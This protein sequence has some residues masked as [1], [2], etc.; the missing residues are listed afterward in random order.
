LF[1]PQF[2]GYF[3]KA[4][5]MRF[6]YCPQIVYNTVK[7]AK[8]RGPL[9]SFQFFYS[10]VTN[11]FM[12][13][14]RY[15]LSLSQLSHISSLVLKLLNANKLL[16]SNKSIEFEKIKLERSTAPNEILL[17]TYAYTSIF[18]TGVLRV[19]YVQTLK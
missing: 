6:R 19:C 3:D 5:T 7:I 17:N 10:F 4:E 12:T 1:L 9:D 16:N 18:F 14:V 8:T 2:I 11:S 13:R 15:A